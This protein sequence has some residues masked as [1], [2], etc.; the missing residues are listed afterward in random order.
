MV[1]ATTKVDDPLYLNV[2]R[3]LELKATS[4]PRRI[5]L[6]PRRKNKT[7]EFQSL[8]KTWS[9]KRRGP[10]YRKREASSGFTSTTKNSI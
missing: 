7:R 8:R 10:D 1:Q 9:F 2:K 6:N 3:Y 5:R 4:F